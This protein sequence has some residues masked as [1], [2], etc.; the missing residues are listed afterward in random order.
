VSFDPNIRPFVTPNRE[1]IGPLVERHVSHA[2]VVK[3]S[4]EDLEWLYPGRGPEESLA[5]W[6]KAGPRFCVATLGERGALAMLGEERIAVPAPQ[7]EVA[8]TVGAGDS[9]MS[10]LLSAMDRD[11]ALGAEAPTPSRSELER[12]LRFAAAASAITC[13][14]KG[15][16][17][18]TLKEVQAALR[19]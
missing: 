10:A 16:D 3:A 2:R 15:S 9:F 12:W 1:A 13:T 11:H 5:A 6:A 14:R 4:E 7:V 19:P 17:P 18:P 8:D